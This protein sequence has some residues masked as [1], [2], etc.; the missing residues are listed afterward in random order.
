MP[1]STPI[2]I[3][4]VTG[5]L[6][7]QM[8]QYA[9]ALALAERLGGRV[10]LEVSSFKRYAL[11]QYELDKLNIPQQFSEDL[12]FSYAL[13][14]IPSRFLRN[15]SRRSGYFAGVYKEPNFHFDEAFTRI[16]GSIIRVKGY[17]NSPLYFS[18]CENILREQLR[19]KELLNPK[20]QVYHEQIWT[21]P[22]AVSL[23]VRRGDY[24]NDAGTA[25]VHGSVAANYWHRAI[26]LIN[27]IVGDDARY[28]LFSDD[29][30]YLE[31][32]FKDLRNS[33]VVRSE[34]KASFEDMH[35]MSACQHHIIANSSYSWWGAWLS[36]NPSKTVIA[37]AQWFT[38]AMM[39]KTNTMDLYPEGWILL[40]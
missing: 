17:F 7:N 23:H 25:A 20:A 40:R 1:T 29:P 5:G 13:R 35:L 9:A 2:I 32:E 26:G 38:R 28:F 39:A 11:R 33:V 18:G 37:P 36:N 15:F 3:V 10:Y 21:T 34:A 22:K 8:F 12:P 30:D 19:P 16:S 14:E 31:R 24:V 27:H 6:G 4:R